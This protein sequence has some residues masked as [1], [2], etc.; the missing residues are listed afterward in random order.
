M[1][2]AAQSKSGK[3]LL[4][5]SVQGSLGIPIVAKQMRRLFEPCGGVA[6]QDVPAATDSDVDSDEKDLSYEARAEVRKAERARNDSPGK[7]R[8]K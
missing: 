5:A 7:S 4:L 3:S 8:R 1:Q 6:K 2:N